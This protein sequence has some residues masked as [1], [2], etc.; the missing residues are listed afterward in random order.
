M[1]TQSKID[2][3]IARYV[4]SEWCTHISDSY[5]C[6][7]FTLILLA[8]VTKSKP[9][10][11]VE[12]NYKTDRSSTMSVLLSNLLFSVS[13]AGGIPPE[14]DCGSIVPFERECARAIVS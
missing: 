1:V 12:G 14:L 11:I 4:L 9:L 3:S 2:I 5:R 8:P 13:Y 10:Y 7:G 6:Q